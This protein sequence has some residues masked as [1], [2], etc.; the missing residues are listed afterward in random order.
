MRPSPLSVLAVTAAAVLFGMTA[1]SGEALEMQLA[2]IC[3][4]TCP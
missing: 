1:P 4:P 2:A 3:Q